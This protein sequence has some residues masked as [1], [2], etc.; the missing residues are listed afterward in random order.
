MGKNQEYND[1]EKSS[2]NGDDE[3]FQLMDVVLKRNSKISS[4]FPEE[5]N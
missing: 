3:S 2:L 4:T 1:L 5:M